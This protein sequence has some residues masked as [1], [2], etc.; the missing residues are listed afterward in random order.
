MTLGPRGKEHSSDRRLVGVDL[1][2]CVAIAVVLGRHWLASGLPASENLVIDN[3]AR[4]FFLHGL[5]GVTLFFV[6]SGFLITRTTMA[7]EAD[8]FTLSFRGFYLRR[9]SRILPL[10]AV[11]ITVGALGLALGADSRLFVLHDPH[12]PFGFWF[13]LS[14]FTFTFNWALAFI[15]FPDGW[16]LHWD[17]LWSLAVEEQFYVLFPLVVV[18]ARWRG[19]LIR[20]LVAAIALAIITRSV[21]VLTGLPATYAIFGSL[22]CIDALA[23]GVLT[24][25]LSGRLIADAKLK[26]VMAAAGPIVIGATYFSTDIVI[27]PTILALGAAL[28]IVGVQSPNAFASK[29]WL[30]FARIGELSYGIYLFHPAIL[31]LVSPLLRGSNFIGGYLLFLG[32]TVAFADLSYRYLERPANAWIRRSFLRVRPADELLIVHPAAG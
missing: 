16:G 27:A 30:P 17:V 24:A 18:L 6:I 11:S 9:A 29:L 5:W 1:L 21:V 23:I 26:A 13:W 14:I 7:R 15:N 4:T 20:A 22:A 19:R 31:Y 3:F 28:F 2:R 10:L 12:A 25:L 32:V 8:F